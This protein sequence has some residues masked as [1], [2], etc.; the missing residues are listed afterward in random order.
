MSNNIYD[1]LFMAVAVRQ[2]AYT[3]SAYTLS[4]YTL[5]WNI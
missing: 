4:A 2:G 3:L 1:K 5:S